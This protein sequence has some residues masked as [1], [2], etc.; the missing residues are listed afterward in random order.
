M[1][2]TRRPLDPVTYAE[3]AHILGVTPSTI[4]R[5][6]GSRFP[7]PHPDESN[8]CPHA[9]RV[10]RSGDVPPTWTGRTEVDVPR[11]GHVPRDLGDA[12][13]WEGVVGERG[14][15]TRSPMKRSDP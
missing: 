10:P 4:R 2:S 5:A 7:T 6:N 11:S 15:R 12:A 13:R 9:A 14:A 1:R 8:C 3:A